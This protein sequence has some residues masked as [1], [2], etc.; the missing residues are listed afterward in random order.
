MQSLNR[1]VKQLKVIQKAWSD[2][3]VDE[4]HLDKEII[5]EIK[6]T[7]RMARIKFIKI[8]KTTNFRFA[9]EINMEACYLYQAYQVST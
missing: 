6:L 3:Q 8:K 7:G 9:D 2:F 4:Y 1:I 5:N